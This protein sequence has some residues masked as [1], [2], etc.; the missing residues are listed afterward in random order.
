MQRDPDGNLS[1]HT[2]AERWHNERPARNAARAADRQVQQAETFWSKQLRS[3]PT[4]LQHELAGEHIAIVRVLARLD[5]DS[6]RAAAV[7]AALPLLSRRRIGASEF[8]ALLSTVTQ[9]DSQAPKV[10]AA[11]R[12]PTIALSLDR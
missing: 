2:I 6:R 9:K 3:L 5:S 10:S 4:R 12:S 11:V 1:A 7:R 8:V